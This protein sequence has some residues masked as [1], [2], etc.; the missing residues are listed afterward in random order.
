MHVQ[1]TDAA[2]TM[3]RAFLPHALLLVCA[4]VVLNGCALVRTAAGIRDPDV[5]IEGVRVADASFDHVDLLFDVAI[6][7]PNKVAATLDSFDYSL[8][9]NQFTVLSGTQ[10]AAVAI[11]SQGSTTVPVPVSLRFNDLYRLYSDLSDKDEV[12]YALLAELNFDVPV[13]GRVSVPVSREGTLPMAK[14]PMISVEDLQVERLDFDSADV[15]LVLRI[16][17]PN[18]FDMLLEN[19]AYEFTVDGTEWGRGS[20][21]ERMSVNEKGETMLRLPFRLDLGAMGQAVQGLLRGQRQ[22]DY[23]LKGAMTVDTTSSLI[24]HIHLPIDKTGRI[25]VEH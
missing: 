25:G 14:E 8:E 19:L 11:A 20:I 10:D 16:N 9:L 3:T 17:N 13:L 21:R 7:N 23:R 6:R 22:F 24:R 5:R 15:E 2:N 1:P 18:A 12:D 4:A